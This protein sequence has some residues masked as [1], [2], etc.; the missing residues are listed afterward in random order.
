MVIDL[1]I[2]NARIFIGDPGDVYEGCLGIENGKIVAIT[3][4]SSMIRSSD[5]FDAKGLLVIPGLIDVDTHFRVPGMTHKED[6]FTGTSAAAAGGITTVLDMPNTNPPTTTR[7]RL[8]EKKKLVEKNAVV[9]YGFHFAAAVDNQ[10][11]IETV[12]DIASVKFFMAGHETTPTTVD[13]EGIL[14]EEFSILKKRGMI[15]TVHAENQRLIKYLKEKYKYSEDFEAYNESRN[16][17]VVHLAT[18]EVIELARY[19]GNR[20]HICHS[21]TKEELEMINAA[22]KSGI[23]ITCEVVPY[24]LF[25]TKDDATKL[26]PYGKVSP[27]LKSGDDQKAL[28]DGIENGVVDCIASEHTPHTKEEKEKGVWEAPAGMPGNE[29]MLPLLISS[30]LSLNKI[31]KLTSENPA[32]IFGIKDKGKIALGYDAD[33]VILDPKEEWVVKGDELKTKCGWSAFE[34]MKLKGKPQFT[35][36]RGRLVYENGEIDETES[37]CYGRY[38]EFNY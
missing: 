27:A 32:R 25:L 33:L 35:M 16:N 8:R 13:D 14:F 4:D 2:K 1:L 3:K 23:D 30:G 12:N 11:E 5:V 19:I 26:G 20:V 21:S 6:F 17:L 18:A 36:V 7:E 38:I 31:V 9:D 34:G 28:W 37:R 29:T 22:K 24:H 15:A 10:S